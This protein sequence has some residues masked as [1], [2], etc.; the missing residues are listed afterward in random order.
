MDL[1]SS[2]SDYESSLQLDENLQKS[3]ESIRL[4]NYGEIALMVEQNNH[5]EKVASAS[6]STNLTSVHEANEV[7][8]NDLKRAN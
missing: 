6:V 5:S 8:M 1:K 4:E 3:L 2:P 7:K